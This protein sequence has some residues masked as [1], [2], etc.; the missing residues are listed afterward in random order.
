MKNL[1]DDAFDITEKMRMHPDTR[2]FM[3]VK[4]KP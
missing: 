3:K 1:Q 4:Q 2:E